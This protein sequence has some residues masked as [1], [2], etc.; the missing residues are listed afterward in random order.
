MAEGETGV[1]DGLLSGF[2]ATEEEEREILEFARTPR[3]LDRDIPVG[4]LSPDDREMLLS[5][6][7][8]LTLA[9]GTQSDRERQLLDALAVLLGY[10][11]EK[12][13]AIIAATREGVES[14]ARS[15]Q[16]G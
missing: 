9:D 6:A 4:E 12:A 5:N 3:S 1:I 7:A 2:D 14:L 16:D 11:P 13:Q 8:L 15:D 10:E